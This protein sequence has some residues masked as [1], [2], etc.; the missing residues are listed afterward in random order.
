[1][2]S[3]SGSGSGRGH[4]REGPRRS[5]SM[6]GKG[7]MV[8][9]LGHNDSTYHDYLQRR[10]YAEDLGLNFPTPPLIISESD[11][12]DNTPNLTSQSEN[13][14]DI[15][16]PPDFG[17]DTPE[18]D[19]EREED[20]IQKQ[21]KS[22]LFVK[23]M[24]KIRSEDGSITV[25]CNYCNKVYKW[26]RSGGYGT[27]WKH[28]EAKHPEAVIRMRSQTQIPR[29]K[30]LL[31]D[32]Y[33]EYVTIYGSGTPIVDVTRTKTASQPPSSSSGFMN[34]GYS[35]FSKKNKKPRC[36]SSSSDSH[37]ELES[38]LASSCDFPEEF[39][40]LKYWSDATKYY[41]ILA[42]IA[43]N[44]FSTPVSTV[45]VEQEFSAG[46]NILDEKRS[47]LTPKALQIQVCVDDWTKAEYRQQELQQEPTYDFFKEDEPE[48]GEGSGAS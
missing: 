27:Y 32:L 2:A 18:V 4:G 44:I 6:H 10:A 31:Y 48:A 8:D 16:T 40:L 23:H 41:P 7:P 37:A 25:A 46:G 38:Y 15:D 30:K 1:M 5:I 26:S 21:S 13:M 9:N 19:L 28:I 45:A 17:F 3:G 36:S 33:D 42:M 14:P 24:K 11:P 12:N 47:C 22:D 29:V 39:E 35:M 43:K 34:L 20:L